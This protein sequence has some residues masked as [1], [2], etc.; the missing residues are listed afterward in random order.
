MSV[1][2]Q[3]VPP[4]AFYSWK[5]EKKEIEKERERKGKTVDQKATFK[6]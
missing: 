1:I 3:L 6:S 5:Q 4:K 2:E